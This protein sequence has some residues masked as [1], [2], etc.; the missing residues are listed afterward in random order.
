MKSKPLG[1]DH[2][3]E[4]GIIASIMALCRVGDSLYP[5]KRNGGI[6]NESSCNCN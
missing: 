6:S 3:I 2:E 4:G 5:K 1:L